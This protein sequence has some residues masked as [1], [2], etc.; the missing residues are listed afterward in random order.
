[1]TITAE[2]FTVDDDPVVALNTASIEGMRMYISN[3]GGQSAA[4]G[5]ADV[6]LTTGYVIASSGTAIVEI[7]PGDVLYAISNA[8][9]TTLEVLRT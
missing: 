9:S 6:L 2:S 8:T 1:M 5:P 4:I 7:K 3:T